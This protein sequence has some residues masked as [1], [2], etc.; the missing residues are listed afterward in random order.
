ML[1]AIE[2]HRDEL[3]AL[4][5]R[6]GA[7]R[8]DAFGSVARGD[9]DPATSDMDFIVEFD[10]LAP[11]SFADAYFTLKGELETLFGRR[12]DLLTEQNLDNPF[13]RR[14]VEVERRLVY[15]R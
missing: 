11:M 9:F 4:C 7:Q 10:S 2:Q 8:L 5:R 12:V 13:L 1:D 15:A 6:V 14:R 3:D